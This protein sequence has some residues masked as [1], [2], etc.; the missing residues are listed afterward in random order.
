MTVGEGGLSRGDRLAVWLV[1]VLI[2]ALDTLDVP[3]S[4]AD[5]RV[6]SLDVLV[7]EEVFL[8][9]VDI[10]QRC[11]LTIIRTIIVISAKS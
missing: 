8:D 5:S 1:G 7:V 11:H 3:A 9:R 4:V 2:V 10:L 6:V